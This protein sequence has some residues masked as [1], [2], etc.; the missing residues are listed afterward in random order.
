MLHYTQNALNE[1]G[2]FFLNFNELEGPYS[3]FS[4]QFLLEQ[5][6]LSLGLF[7]KVFKQQCHFDWL[8]G[9][10]EQQYKHIC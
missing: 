2:L 4:H 9:N 8:N 1:L 10:W 3:V 5:W 6:P 7:P